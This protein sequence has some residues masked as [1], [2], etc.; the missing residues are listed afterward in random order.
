MFV[1]TPRE[2]QSTSGEYKFTP[3]FNV[4]PTFKDPLIVVL[5]RF[6]SPRTLRVLSHKI[7][8]LI[9]DGEPT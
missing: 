9:S 2:E 5:E 1:E 6:V 3:T 4:V 7:F 8:A